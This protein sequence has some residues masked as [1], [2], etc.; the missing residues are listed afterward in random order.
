[1]I[2]ADLPVRKTSYALE[3]DDSASGSE[4]VLFAALIAA[5]SGTTAILGMLEKPDVEGSAGASCHAG[6]EDLPVKVGM[7]GG[8][9]TPGRVVPRLR[10]KVL[11]DFSSCCS[12]AR[13]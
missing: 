1:M 3:E 5:V 6:M 7:G 8:V 11:R 2:S 13:L 10:S 9:E 4:A 12:S